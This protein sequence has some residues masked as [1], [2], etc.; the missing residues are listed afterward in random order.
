MSGLLS[1]ISYLSPNCFSSCADF[2]HTLSVGHVVRARDN[3]DLALSG[4]LFSFSSLTAA[5]QIASLS[6]LAA[7]AS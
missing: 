7:N 3:K 2:I 1:Y 4:S 5:N 6:G